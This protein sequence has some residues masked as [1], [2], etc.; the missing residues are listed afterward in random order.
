LAGGVRRLLLAKAE[1]GVE[2][3]PC[4]GTKTPNEHWDREQ[5]APDAPE[6]PLEEGGEVWNRHQME[7]DNTGTP[8][9][10]D[11]REAYPPDPAN[12]PDTEQADME[13]ISGRGKPSGES[14]W[15]RV[16]DSSKG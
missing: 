12:V 10:G 5:W 16:D 2:E 8:H 14:H 1:A 15:G 13:H 11:G 4:M 7:F 6:A 9:E 3:V